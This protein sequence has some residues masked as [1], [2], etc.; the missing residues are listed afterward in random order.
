MTPSTPPPQ[1][2]TEPFPLFLDSDRLT[3]HFAT[4]LVVLLDV[5]SSQTDSAGGL[6]PGRATAALA[7]PEDDLSVQPSAA[8]SRCPLITRSLTCEDA[9]HSRAFPLNYL[10]AVFLGAVLF[11]RVVITHCR[12]PSQPLPHPS[13]PL[14]PLLYS[15]SSSIS[16]PFFILSCF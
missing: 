2:C 7:A 16:T 12:H 1:P 6:F 13:T 8:P 9:Q 4:S 11:H 5:N 15:K 10:T 3:C 14:V